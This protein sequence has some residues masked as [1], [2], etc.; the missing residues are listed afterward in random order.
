[1]KILL[2]DDD[3]ILVSL[4][5]AH[6]IEEHYIVD[7]AT[8]GQEAWEFVETS[9][10][11]LIILDVMLPKLD[12]ISLCQR[13]RKKGDKTLILLLT[14]KGMSDDKIMGLNAGADDY[15]VKPVP[16][17]E[18]AAK[19][20]ALL[21]R[22]FSPTSSTLRWGN[23]CLNFTKH[24]AF[25][26][27]TLLNLTSK[28][29]ALLELL[30][31]DSEKIYSQ[32]TILNQLWSLTDDL[33]GGDT[34]RALVKRLRQK[35]KAVSNE[36]LIE[37]IYGVGYRLNPKFVTDNI[38]N[39]HS[40]QKQ[41][42]NS[43]F[44]QETKSYVAKELQL[45][46]A[47][48]LNKTGDAAKKIAHKMISHMGILGLESGVEIAIKLE[49]LFSENHLMSS[50]DIKFYHQ[51][52]QKLVSLVEDISIYHLE[53]QFNYQ[54]QKKSEAKLLILDDDWITLRFLQTLLEPWG[55]QVTLSKEIQNFWQQLEIIK[56]DLLILD[57]QMPDV[58]GLELCQQLR[59]DD[60]WAWIPII[61]L[62]GKRDAETI[63]QVFTV[64]ADDY[65][66]KPVVAPE[67]ITRLFNRL[68][69]TRLL[70]EYR[71]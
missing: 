28:E 68:E 51:Q 47:S 54:Q 43:E 37:N 15:I 1:M 58:N 2:V 33:P 27:D 61:F 70:Q 30:L 39:E 49:Q 48:I 21:R 29:Y 50:D 17:P 23:I 57:I 46:E 8:D 4:L 69:R 13:L 6:L 19:I 52:V 5:N 25:Y 14:A 55:L 10:Y 18:L 3:P 59:N 35:L 64:G 44:W 34:V 62:T 16:L 26:N 53:Q 22:Q 38:Q 12:G 71:K 42:I 11:D 65:V 40:Y 24:E 41:K 56:P 7:I 9:H 66:S 60:K 20:R 36:D 31:H 32:T 45:L 67:L 63:Q